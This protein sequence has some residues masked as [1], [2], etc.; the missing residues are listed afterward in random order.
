MHE[1]MSGRVFKEASDKPLTRNH[2]ITCVDNV[3]VSH[4][5]IVIGFLLDSQLT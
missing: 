3:T 5:E 4:F 2:L 1:Q